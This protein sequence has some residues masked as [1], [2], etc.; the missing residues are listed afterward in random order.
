MSL[1]FDRR[2]SARFSFLLSAPIIAGAGGYELLKLIIRHGTSELT[3][4][5][6]FGFL[7]A[8]MSGYVAIAFLMRFLTR[9]TFYP[10][11]FYRLALAVIV[12]TVLVMGG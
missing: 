5:Y 6:L 3:I 12:A 2:T 7:S 10:F 8:A 11:I 1:G 9:H 4:Q